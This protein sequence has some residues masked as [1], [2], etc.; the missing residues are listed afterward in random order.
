[1]ES[2]GWVKHVIIPAMHVRTACLK[3]VPV[4]DIADEIARK[5]HGITLGT[6]QE[7]R[8]ALKILFLLGNLWALSRMTSQIR[9]LTFSTLPDGLALASH[10]Y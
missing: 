1:M 7:V 5:Y 8:M 2:R 3:C 10:L 4:A 6:W 9:E